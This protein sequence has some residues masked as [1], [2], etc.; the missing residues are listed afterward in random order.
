MMRCIENAVTAG[1]IARAD[2]ERLQR[3]IDEKLRA[4]LAPKDVREVIAKDLEMAA[5]Q[6]RR[7]A[8]LQEARRKV[9]TDQMLN[10]RNARG[11]IDPAEALWMMVEHYT[12]GRGITDL[13]GLKWA[14]IRETHADLAQLLNEFR[15]GWLNGD[16]RRGDYK[17]PIV[18]IQVGGGPEIVARMDNIVRELF[19]EGTGDERAK[20]LAQ[21]WAK[22]AEKLRVRFNEAGGNIGKLEHWGLPQGHNAEALLAIG[23]SKWVDYL[24]RPG[25][26]DREKMK[27]PLTGKALDDAELREALGNV[28]ETIT[29]DGWIDREPSE[30][31]W[32]RGALAKRRDEHH[33]FLHFKD[34]KA[35]LAYHRDFRAGDPFESMMGHISVMARD[36][37]TLEVLGPN[38]DNMRNYLKQI[39]RE[40][41]ARSVPAREQVAERRA[42]ALASIQRVLPGEVGK[43]I[44]DRITAKMEQLADVQKKALA[45]DSDELRAKARIVANEMY[46]IEA[47]LEKLEPVEITQ[48]RADL[49]GELNH[50]RGDLKGVFGKSAPQ[51]E[52]LSRRNRRR[53]EALRQR[54]AEITAELEGLDATDTSILAQRPEV[55]QQL[56]D[57]FAEL[58][59]EVRAMRDGRYW[60][61][62]NPR[63]ASESAIYR[64][65]RMWD[66]YRGNHYAPVN[67]TWANVWQTGRN[68]ATHLLLGSSGL[69][70]LGDI[71]NLRQARYLAGLGP[72]THK[73]LAG[74]L[75]HLKWD[76]VRQVEAGLLWDS[77]IHVMHQQARFLEHSGFMSQS[78]QTIGKKFV[79]WSGFLAD[80]TVTMSGMAWMTQGAK[81]AFGTAI[82]LE[83]ARRV[84]LPFDELPAMMK[85]AFEDYGISAE[86]WDAMRKAQIYKPQEGIAWLRPNEVEKAAGRDV[87][88]KYLMLIHKLT[89]YGVIEGTVKSRS[90]SG[91]ERRGTFWG[92]SQVAMGQ[93]ASFGVAHIIMWAGKL[94]REFQMGN[95]GNAASMAA[96]IAVGGAIIGAV[97]NEL[98]EL[99]KG[100]D[101]VITSTLAKGKLP[102]P[103]YWGSA[104]LKSGGLGIYG[105]FLFAPFDR[106]GQ[107]VASRMMGPV[108]SQLERLRV[109]GFQ[110]ASD[111]AED[112]NKEGKTARDLV[113]TAR[114]FFPFGSLWYLQLV[115]ERLVLNKLQMM[116]DPHAEDVFKRH[117]QLE[118]KRLGNGFWWHAGDSQPARAPMFV[119][120]ETLVPRTGGGRGSGRFAPRKMP[121]QPAAPETGASVGPPLG[122][123]IV[124]DRS[125]Q[126]SVVDGDT[127][128]AAGQRWRLVGF[129]A[130]EVYSR[131]KTAAE[132]TAGMKAALRLQDLI[133]GGKAE[134]EVVD[135]PD[136]WG[137]GR[138]RLRVDGRDV[139]DILAREGLAK[140][141]R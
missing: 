20:A 84:H 96:G 5:M 82:Q 85:R 50:V 26:L 34:G 59:R 43:D 100:K 15:K 56:I 51:L 48:R 65:D 25:V 40:H 112:K 102:G 72:D 45:A 86:D 78:A 101:P 130:P 18:G 88:E 39:V 4:G 53:V 69:S 90:M 27:S 111:W 136:K 2:G 23:Q 61:V 24:M 33:R 105:D 97:V 122:T 14:I 52:G 129:D 89:R 94:M 7:R 71:N 11:E 140:K 3:E 58:K 37:A 9:L 121:A 68:L 132:R 63:E 124:Q 123:R 67:S 47:E 110:E 60:S 36:I 139:G 95:A 87:A 91:S 133:K 16:L 64:S 17:L 21:S 22:V 125:T 98:F 32:G 138:A 41:A 135:K 131:A 120:D 104:L 83:Y 57:A 115:K 54:E 29:T 80:R 137:R 66:V 42:A 114:D 141:A 77:A 108:Y 6:K 70:T 134:I 12:G 28:W 117:E 62:D 116:F 38:P 109:R 119:P 76:P 127:I 113:G 79:N 128:Y 55:Y 118:G 13:E 106:Y 99:K 49:T 81:W 30:A 107:G 92:E 93:F 35:W 73:I 46:A 103:E 10:H 44:V 74:Y 126:F 75:E 8:L 1:H 19:G 31:A